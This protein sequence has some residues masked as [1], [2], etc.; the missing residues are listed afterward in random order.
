MKHKS[1]LIVLLVLILTGGTYYYKNTTAVA[2]ITFDI[3][4]SIE[5][6]TNDS[7]KVVKY[8]AL[9]EDGETLLENINLKNLT[10]DKATEIIFNKAI[11][12]SYINMDDEDNAILVTV[13]DA[14]EEEQEEIGDL[15]ETTITSL[16]KEKAMKVEVIK[17]GITVELKESALEYGISN[18]KMMYIT[19]IS[20]QYNFDIE[21]LSSLSIKEINNKVKE[22]K[23]NP[24]VDNANEK[25]KVDMS[26]PDVRAEQKEIKDQEK[27]EKK[28]SKN[29]VEDETIT[30]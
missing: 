7:N 2:T 15:V 17:Q 5:L 20:N 25:S 1:F 28:A 10:I 30:E 26:D 23:G 3:N 19:K 24:S 4:P 13:L 18:G 9:N 16:S 12:L 14:D 27:A 8:Q 29:S 11:E 22:V 6:S 21:E